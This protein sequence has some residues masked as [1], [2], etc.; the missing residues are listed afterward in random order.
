MCAD[1]P[2][3]VC[4]SNHKLASVYMLKAGRL[5]TFISNHNVKVHTHNQTEQ[6]CTSLCYCIQCIA[7]QYVHYYYYY[8]ADRAQMRALGDEVV[9]IN[10]EMMKG[11]LS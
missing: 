10:F 4:R 9:N 1:L 2:V 3:V 8:Y 7:I 11:S 5:I 6:D